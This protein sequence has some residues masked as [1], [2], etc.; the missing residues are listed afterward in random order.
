[1]AKRIMREFRL[2]EISAVDR[3]AQAHAKMVIMKRDVSKDMYGVS[4]FADII[5]SIG[6]LLQCSQCEANNEGDGSLVPEKLRGWLAAGAPIFEAMAREEIDELIASA[7][8]KSDEATTEAYSARNFL[9]EI[10]KRDFTAEQRRTAASSGAALPDGSFPIENSSDLHNAMRAIG[11]AKDPAKAKAHIR[12]RAKTLGL[13]SELSDAFKSEDGMLG[14][15]LATLSAAFGRDLTKAVASGN[16]A[17]PQED[18]MFEAIKKALGLAATATEDEVLKALTAK[19]AAGD[20]AKIAK[21]EFDLAIAK[22]AMSADE[23]EYH[24]GLDK[25][26]DRKAFREKSKDDRAKEM[27]AR[28]NVEL[29]ESVKK[30]L[31]ENDDLKKRLGVLENERLEKQFS[32]KAVVL[33]LPAEKGAIL[34]KAAAGDATAVEEV[35]KM[36]GQANAALENSEAFSEFGSSVSKTG[37]ANDQLKAKAAELRKADPKLTPEQAFAKAYEDP[38]NVDLVRQER[39]E[40]RPNAN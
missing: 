4:R 20:A 39:R 18:A 26:E 10:E 37:D 3:P 33:G 8:T 34:R 40:N 36:L 31:A 27:K 28:K 30:A 17:D 23:K 6:Y 24:D 32:E 2:D 22:A 35:F 13:T 7:V 19:V 21:L 29:P 11:R 16:D 14:K 12:S 38:A 5:S 9:Q 25:E 1:M 15:V